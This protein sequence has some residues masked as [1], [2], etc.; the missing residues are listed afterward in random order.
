M[1]HHARLSSFFYNPV[2]LSSYRFF[3]GS[4][5]K[6]KVSKVLCNRSLGVFVTPFWLLNISFKI[7][8]LSVIASLTGLCGIP[9]TC[10]IICKKL[11]YFIRDICWTTVNLICTGIPIIAITSNKCVITE[12]AFSEVKAVTQWILEYVS[13]IWCTH[14]VYQTR[15]WNIHLP[16]FIS[17]G[18]FRVSSCR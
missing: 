17:L 4:M 6:F 7:S 13:I 11:F 2:S 5:L 18:T 14:T 8:D 12:S 9:I 10:F 15:K 1:C 3:F 16:N